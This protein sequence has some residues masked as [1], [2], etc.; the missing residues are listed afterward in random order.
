MSKEF[1]GVNDP[2]FTPTFY[3]G[4]VIFFIGHAFGH[5]LTATTT[6]TTTILSKNKL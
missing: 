1:Y 5:H 3:F 4:S 2:D 6:I